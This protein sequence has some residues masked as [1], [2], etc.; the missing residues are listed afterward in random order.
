MHQKQVIYGGKKP[1]E[2]NR[3]L[4]LVHG[5]G[6]SAEDMLALAENFEVEDFTLVAPKASH[7]TWY[8]FSF[9]APTDQNE[10]WLSSAIKVLEEVVEE[11]NKHGFAH[12]QI[13]FAGFS[14]GACLTLEF[15]TQHAKHWGGVAAFTGGLIG[16][17]LNTE[18]YKGN[19]EGTPIFIGTSD[20][21]PH[22]PVS[23]VN[24]TV[25]IL[26][27][28]NAEVTLKVYPGMAHTINM[29]EIEQANNLIFKTEKNYVPGN[30]NL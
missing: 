30:Q 14:Q 1:A 25:K 5:R 8:P 18:Q 16:E 2:A 19:F 3:A 11:L 20:P 9:M 12:E 27:K 26:Q 7:N 29:D 28:M 15:V 13:Y 23:R 17:E 6:G 21:D 10:P 22:V 4:I 24:E